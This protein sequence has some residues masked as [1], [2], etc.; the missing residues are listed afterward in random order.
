MEEHFTLTI[1]Q[2]G[3][4]PACFAQE[5]HRWAREVTEPRAV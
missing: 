3:S 1:R 4:I 2:W 5:I